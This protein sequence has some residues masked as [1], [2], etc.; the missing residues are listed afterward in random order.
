MS[1]LK[2]GLETKYDHENADQR[3]ELSR[4]FD[5]SLS[6]SL[7]LCIFFCIFNDSEFAVNWVAGLW[8]EA[9][10]TERWGEEAG[11]RVLTMTFGL[12]TSA[13]SMI[14]SRCSLT[15]KRYY[16]MC[17]K[18]RWLLCYFLIYTFWFNL[19]L[20]S[21][22][23]SFFCIK[24]KLPKVLTEYFFDFLSVKLY[25]SFS[26]HSMISWINCRE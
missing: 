6:F 12:L 4:L 20:I 11:G 7:R 13:L 14:K 1:H 9:V 25:W 23:F 2:G 17:A 21:N 5:L 24:K 22:T 8:V 10:C 16:N 15:R 3:R 18:K 26:I 19:V